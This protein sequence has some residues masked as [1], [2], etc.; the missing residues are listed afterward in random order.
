MLSKKAIESETFNRKHVIFS[1]L[2]S[3]PENRTLIDSGNEYIITSDNY[4]NHKYKIKIL[5]VINNI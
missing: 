5:K 4:N 2:I 1:V 3:L